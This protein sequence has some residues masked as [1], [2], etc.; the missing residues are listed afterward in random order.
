LDIHLFEYVKNLN[1]K[2]NVEKSWFKVIL[3][4]FEV[5]K[6]AFWRFFSPIGGGTS[7]QFLPI[8]NRY[9]NR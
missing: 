6:L 9:S 3:L 4:A 7:K 8:L 5:K 2:K 1:I